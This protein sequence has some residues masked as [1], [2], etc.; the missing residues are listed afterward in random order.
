VDVVIENAADEVVGVEVKAKATVQRND[1]SGLRR[2]ADLA[3]ENFMGGFLLYDGCDTLPM[4]QRLWAV[5][6]STLWQL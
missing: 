5:P 3:G 1:F 6:L 2:L 4:G